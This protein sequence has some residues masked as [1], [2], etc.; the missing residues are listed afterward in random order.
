MGTGAKR[1]NRAFA[2]VCVAL[3]TLLPAT[4]CTSETEPEPSAHARIEVD[5][6]SALADEPLRIR[7]GGLRPGEE[8]TVASSAVDRDGLSWSAQGRFTAD[9]GG[10]VDLTR[11]KPNSGTYDRADGMGLFWSM[12]PR[13]GEADESWFAPRSPLRAA[14]YDV[15][16]AVRAGQREIAH[17]TLTRRLRAEGVRHRTLTVADDGLDGALFLP[18]DA[19]PRAAPVLLFGGSEGGRGLDL[20]AAMLASRGH[21]ALSLCYFGCEGRPSQLRDIELEYFVRAARLLTDL[22]GAA[23]DRL[24]VMGGSRGSE[25]A[26]LLA[27]Y[28][29]GLVRDAVAV[30]PGTRTYWPK[31]GSDAEKASWT[32]DGRPVLLDEIPLDHVRGTVLAVAG[33]KDRLWLAGPAAESI[34]RRTN[35]AGV[36]HRALMYD[37]AG[38][39]VMGAPYRAAGKYIY[40]PSAKRWTDLGGTQAA[41]ARAK[42]DSWPRI[43]ELIGR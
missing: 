10:D 6:P 39:G 9:D 28:H 17:R 41:D 18:R 2:A 40:D 34:A 4:A 35:A 27:Q 5:R 12:R 42:A 31:A 23:P 37:E 8:V 36:R 22:P 11:H 15:R 29:P 7:V 13:R 20:E 43:L 38:H 25:A 3:L 19:A 26:Q 1:K 16:I 33:R 21:P 32:R 14:S 30:A 24:A